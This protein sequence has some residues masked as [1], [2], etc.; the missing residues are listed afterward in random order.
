MDKVL[1]EVQRMLCELAH[2]LL[3]FFGEAAEHKIGSI[4]LLCKFVGNAYAYTGKVKAQVGNE[5][6][7]T[8]ISRV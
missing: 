8:I 3:F 4:L 7:N 6:L 5:T 1:N 2:L